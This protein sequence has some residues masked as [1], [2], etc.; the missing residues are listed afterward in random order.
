MRLTHTVTIDGS[1]NRAHLSAHIHPSEHPYESPVEIRQT[2]SNGSVFLTWA[3]FEAVA[4]LVRTHRPDSAVHEEAP[5][6]CSG[7]MGN[8][9]ECALNDN[10]VNPIDEHSGP[11]PVGGYHVTEQGILFAVPAVCDHNWIPAE[12][13][14]GAQAGYL[15]CGKCGAP[16]LLAF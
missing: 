7:R 6:K 9:L 1:P 3:E 14:D 5:G 13:G 10:H 12:D 2:G 8:I 16:Q 15:H 11:N 4:D